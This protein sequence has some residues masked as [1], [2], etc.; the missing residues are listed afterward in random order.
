MCT[1]SCV[2]YNIVVAFLHV[3]TCKCMY[4]CV[5]LDLY[6]VLSQQPSGNYAAVAD[7][8]YRELLGTST[9]YMYMYT[10]HVAC[11]CMC[12][13]LWDITVLHHDPVYMQWLIYMKVQA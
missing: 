12:T 7:N 10:L 8:P 1:S 13:V 9:L 2:Q 6:D 11:M 4:S 3:H 5:Q